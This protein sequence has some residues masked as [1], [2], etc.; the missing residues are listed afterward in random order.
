[1]KLF[2][3]SSPFDGHG[4]PVNPMNHFSERLCDAAKQTRRALFITSDPANPGFTKEFSF[5]V[6]KTLELTGI[7]FDEYRILDNRT[8]THAGEWVSDSDFII[9]AGG[10]VPTQ[11]RF[12]HQIG[13]RELMQ[14][15]HGVV[16]GI[17]A[18]SM[19]CADVVYA[20]PELKGEGTDPAY[21]KFLQGLGLTN[22]MLLPHYQYT[23]TCSLDGKKLFEE[24]TYP[25]SM[26]QTFYAIPD[27]S[28]LYAEGGIQKICGEAYLIQDGTCRK[29]CEKEEEIVVG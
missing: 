29:I 10:H 16:F 22:C 9:L 4:E 7:V 19:N 25:D 1:M 28:Y 13:L 20:Q 21:Q 2:L 14:Q 6:C 17:S 11:N 18:G 26:G 5:D 8:I 27:G 15:F 12:F 3:T 23:K 24:I